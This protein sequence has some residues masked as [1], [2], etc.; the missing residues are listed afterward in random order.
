M[1]PKR[2]T[3][4]IGKFHVKSDKKQKNFFCTPIS[5]F[6]KISTLNICNGAKQIYPKKKKQ[7]LR[8]DTNFRKKI[9]PEKVR[10]SRKGKNFRKGTNFRNS[11]KS[12]E[13]Q[14]KTSPHV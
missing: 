6:Q 2:E 13:F 7:I 10:I 14:K 5:R 12:Y 1:G 8:K 3:I 11:K 9:S 4:A